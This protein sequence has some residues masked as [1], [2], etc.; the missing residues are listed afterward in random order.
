M[1]MRTSRFPRRPCS[2]CRRSLALGPPGRKSVSAEG[3]IERET[4]LAAWAGP[5]RRDRSFSFAQPGEEV[6][7]AGAL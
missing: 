4:G 2:P 5:D 3:F 1:T 6:E 7:L